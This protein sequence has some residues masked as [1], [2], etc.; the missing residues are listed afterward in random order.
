MV[1]G[2]ANY[3]KMRQMNNGNA[4]QLAQGQVAQRST[5]NMEATSNGPIQSLSLDGAQ[6]ASVSDK[7]YTTTDHIE[8]ILSLPQGS[9]GTAVFSNFVFM[10][11]P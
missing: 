7:T 8:L 9:A 4:H 6:V 1:L 3:P 5:Y 11:L 2:A 10:P